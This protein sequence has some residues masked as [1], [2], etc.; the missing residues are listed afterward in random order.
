MRGRRSGRVLDRDDGANGGAVRIQ[1]EE[2][3]VVDVPEWTCLPGARPA[4]AW[5]IDQFVTGSVRSDLLKFTSNERTSTM[6][7]GPNI[8]WITL[9][10]TRYDHTSM[11]GYR[12]D[13]TP[14]IQ[15]IA[16]EPAGRSF[17]EC[18]THGMWTGTSSASILTGTTPPTHGLHGGEDVRLTDRLAT[19]PEL[20]SEAGYHTIGIISGGNAGPVVGLDRGFEEYEWVTVPN[21]RNIGVRPL[22][23]Y[24][25]NFWRHG[26]FSTD[27]VWIKL[28]FVMNDLA[29][30]FVSRATAGDRPFFMYLHY[31]D[32]HLPYT[33]PNSFL[34][35]FTD[36]LDVDGSTA[37]DVVASTYDDIYETMAAGCPLSD[38]E[39]EAVQAMYDAELSYVDHCVG[40]LVDAVR[41]ETTGDTVFVVT[42]DH[43]D[44]FG[45]HDLIG[46][47]FLLH[48]ALTHVPLVTHGLD[49]VDDNTEEVVQHVD[50]VRTMLS[51]A[52]VSDP[53]LEGIDLTRDT[54][55]FAV[56]QRTGGNARK[57]LDHIRELNPSFSSE[58]I[59]P[60]TV[61]AF[62][63][64]D[65]KYL[66]ADGPT[67]LFEL[68]DELTD[69][70]DAH[71]DVV[72]RFRSHAEEWLRERAGGT[73]AV[74]R[75]DDLDPEMR[76]HLS[77]MGYLT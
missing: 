3:D 8:V 13:T 5:L 49:G 46:H 10:S 69:V 75:D 59:Y 68:P 28:S 17:S 12:R 67:E 33:P 37:L 23:K 11:S 7:P 76:D 54:R 14:A 16:D 51:T 62:R 72:D 19:V 18:I 57:H 30:R 42:G 27:D 47:Q 43:G 55:Q 9:E 70:S 21:F 53:Q 77:D 24:A 38:E 31:N 40:R 34:D 60:E 22:A 64:T 39:W 52:G 44:L 26:G 71:P 73:A 32:S 56:S 63:S 15:R 25:L 35:R 45:E 65:Y 36:E 66:H 6:A 41:R 4:P 61:T 2:A 50:V 20:L 1:L 74:P 29:K 48:D 58:A